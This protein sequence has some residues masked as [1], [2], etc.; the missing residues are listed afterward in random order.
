MAKKSAVSGEYLITIDDTGS[1]KV[2]RTY[3]NVISSLREI[4]QLKGFEAD[5]KWNTRQFGKKVVDDYGDGK[6][7]E[8]GEYTIEREPSGTIKTYRVYDNVKGALREIADKAGFEYDNSWTTRQFG[9]KLVDFLN[10]PQSVDQPKKEEEPQKK[11]GCLGVLLLG[12][13]GIIA[14]FV[15]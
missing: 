5:S 1:V 7:A 2:S 6:L 11:K 9:N 4:A 12:L 13:I 10:N 14:Y 15:A 3:D 8:V